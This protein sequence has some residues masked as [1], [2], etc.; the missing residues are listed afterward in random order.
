MI[1][2]I[3]F[4]I[5][6]RS[7]PSNNLCTLEMFGRFKIFRNIYFLANF[8]PFISLAFLY[9]LVENTHTHIQSA[10]YYWCT[11]KCEIIMVLSNIS[12]SFSSIAPCKVIALNLLCFIFGVGSLYSYLLFFLALGG[13]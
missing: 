11:Q 4:L 6:P 5:R 1:C 9:F 10:K 12:G 7:D 13:E 2:R 3:E 8:R